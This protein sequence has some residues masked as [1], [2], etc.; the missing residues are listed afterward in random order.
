M[1]VAV[2]LLGALRMADASTEMLTYPARLKQSPDATAVDVCVIV[3]SYNT[4]SNSTAFLSQPLSGDWS[5]VC[6]LKVPN[7]GHDQNTNKQK[8][9]LTGFPLTKIQTS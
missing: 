7:H 4:R 9:S 5:A 6:C 2:C 8:T 1:G 3:S